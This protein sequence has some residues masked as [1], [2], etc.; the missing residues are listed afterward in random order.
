MKPETKRWNFIETN[1]IRILNICSAS[2]L[3]LFEDFFRLLCYF[4]YE[5]ISANFSMTKLLGMVRMPTVCG[6]LKVEI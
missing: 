1:V 3:L 6:I 2:F 5:V 4:R